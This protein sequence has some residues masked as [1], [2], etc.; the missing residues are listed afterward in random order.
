M[1]E[2]QKTKTLREET[3]EVESRIEALE[4]DPKVQ[5]YIELIKKRKILLDRREEINR[6]KEDEIYNKC[7]HIFIKTGEDPEFREQ[8]CV[9]CGLPLRKER[10]S[11]ALFTN[12]MCDF[13][14]AQKLYVRFKQD[15]PKDSDADIAWKIKA[16][17]KQ[18]KEKEQTP[19]AI[20]K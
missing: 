3:N 18:I 4:S 9:K 16:A 17:V 15:D 13:D 14:L 10:A 5:E 19:E 2:A 12:I 20:L 1:N 11:H 6:K 7:M 8:R